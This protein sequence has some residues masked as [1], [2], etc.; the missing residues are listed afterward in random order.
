MT[1][2]TERSDGLIECRDTF[3]SDQPSYHSPLSYQRDAVAARIGAD[4]DL[5]QA[6]PS[7]QSAGRFTH[8]SLWR[9]R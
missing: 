4:V 9:R 8:T 1:E 2:I 3:T 6:T 7:E 5:V